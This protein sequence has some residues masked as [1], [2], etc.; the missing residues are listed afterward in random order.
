MATRCRATR[1]HCCCWLLAAASP[2]K[3][4][5]MADVEGTTHRLAYVSI[6][7]HTHSCHNCDAS[8]VQTLTL[9]IATGT[10]LCRTMRLTSGMCLYLWR[11]TATRAAQAGHHG[12]VSK[13]VCSL[14]QR[15]RH[16]NHPCSHPLQPPACETPTLHWQSH[17]YSYHTSSSISK[18]D[19]SAS[20]ESKQA[21]QTPR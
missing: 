11:N 3:L 7:Q 16:V 13:C 12:A 15:G 2:D 18:L 1:H 4:G 10:C 21:P 19:Y 9:W 20:R 14:S 5:S 17:M 8:C 6:V